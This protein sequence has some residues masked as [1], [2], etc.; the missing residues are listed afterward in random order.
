MLDA[1]SVSVIAATVVFG[2][3]QASPLAM[4]L[5]GSDLGQA[6]LLISMGHLGSALVLFLFF[7]ALKPL[8]DRLRGFFA[9]LWLR[10]RSREDGPEMPHRSLPFGPMTPGRKYFFMGSVAFTFAF[11]SFLGVTATQAVGMKR[12]RALLAVM[13]GC[14][15]SVVFWVTAAFYLSR[16]MDPS[17]VTLGFVIFA[18]ALVLRGRILQ[19][20]VARELVDLGT[21]SIRVL[22]LMADQISLSQIEEKTKL[23][24][25]QLNSIIEKLIEREYIVQEEMEF[26]QMT[27][28]GMQRL[29]SL[30]DWIQEFLETGSDR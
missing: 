9:A 5:L 16:M 14:G 25:D 2:P 3:P 29:G 8:I 21:D 6:F 12:T 7:Q 28:D 11:G 23:Q 22:S 17:L 20:R 26:Y 27:Q 4:R 18:V 1:K 15:L 24:M 30:P 13:L 19:T 10:I